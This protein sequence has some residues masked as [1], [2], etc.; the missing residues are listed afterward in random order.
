MHCTRAIHG[1]RSWRFSSHKDALCY[2]DPLSFKDSAVVVDFYRFTDCHLEVIFDMSKSQI[3][4]Q[5]STTV[6]G[7]DVRLRPPAFPLRTRFSAIFFQT[8]THNCLI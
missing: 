8:V 6:D 4:L 7:K 2:V 1:S 3:R 5:S